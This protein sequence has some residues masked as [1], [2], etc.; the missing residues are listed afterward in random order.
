MIDLTNDQY[1]AVLTGDV[2]GSTDLAAE[3][4]RAL[5][6]LLNAASEGMRKT[7]PSVPFPVDIFR[8]DSW[9]FIVSNPALSWRTGLYFRARVR[10]AMEA[11]VLDTR[12]G[13][14]IGT[15]S[16]IPEENISG[17]DG[18]AFR[19]SGA[20]LDSLEG[21]TGFGIAFPED[22]ES[23]ITEAFGVI[24]DWMDQECRRWTSRQAAAVAGA[25]SGYTQQE[26]ARHCFDGAISQQA[27]AQHLKRAGWQ[28]LERSLLFFESSLPVLPDGEG[29]AR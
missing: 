9:Q 13:I 25:L 27:V 18:T 19:L 24:L 29:G 23:G 7:F 3:D 28:V 20:A 21:G 2:V 22:L 14:G 4:R 8:G 16:F 15:I 17:G 26:I 6:D 5:P 1:W 11:T 12:I 10:S